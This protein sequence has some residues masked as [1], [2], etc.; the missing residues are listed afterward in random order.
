MALR[1][2][3]VKIKRG[4]PQSPIYRQFMRKRVLRVVDILVD[5]LRTRGELG[6]SWDAL[7]LVAQDE[8]K[9]AWAAKL[10]SA[11]GDSL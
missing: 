1:Q 6:K 5:D 8:L 4:G 3:R 10:S 7:D 11:L 9:S 2:Q